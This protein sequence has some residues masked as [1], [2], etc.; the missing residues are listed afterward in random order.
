[1]LRPV[2]NSTSSSPAAT[3]SSTTY[4]MAGVSTT[5]S[6]SLGVA[7]VAGRNRVP[8]PAAGTTALVTGRD[9][10]STLMSRTLRT[11]SRTMGRVGVPRTKQE[12]RSLLRAS[13]RRSAPAPESLQWLAR[14]RRVADLVL[15]VVDSADAAGGPVAAYC[16]MP[17]EPPTDVL[18]ERL[19]ARGAPALLPVVVGDGVLDWVRDA[20][21]TERRP[22]R[23]GI[24]TPTSSAVGR[25][26]A[27][28]VSAGVGVIVVPALAV[29]EAG[30]RLGQG[31]GFYD[32][33]LRGLPAQA[34]GGPLRLAVVGPG[35]VL[36]DGAIPAED[37]D[38]RVDRWV[39]A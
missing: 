12:L 27:A 14:S 24:P 20:G 3:A 37:H 26:S 30:R 18:L 5:G 23:S 34:D 19:L 35:E 32:R 22:D 4:W 11:R 16:S 31:G 9:G 38:E 17:T 39:V 21:P 29:D 28:L 2:T 13:R 8:R 36:A 10:S 15:A 6:I 7:F 33:L 1:M 25:G